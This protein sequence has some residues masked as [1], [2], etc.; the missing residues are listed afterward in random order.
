[1]LTGVGVL[2]AFGVLA[3]SYAYVGLV[4][5]PGQMPGAVFAAW[6]H[7]W[8]WFP[9]LVLILLFVPM[10]FPTGRPL[11][12]RWNWL[13]W[14]AVAVLTLMTVASWTSPTLTDGSIDDPAYAVPNPIGLGP[15]GTRFE[16]SALAG[17]LF[18]AALFLALC[19]VLS[20]IIRFRRSRDVERQQMKLFLY[21][22][23]L[24]AALPITESL[25]L[26]RFLPDTN[27]FFGI[28]IALPPIAIGVAV[29]RY[30]LYEIDRLISR[31][32][33]YA[34]LTALLIAVYLGS[35]T[36]LTAVTAPVTGDSPAAVAVATLVAAALF[37]PARR[38][39]Q[40]AVDRRFNRARYDAALTLDAYRAA[41]RDELDLTAIAAG[42][43]AAAD[44]TVE[45]SR[46]LV[47]LRP[48]TP[49]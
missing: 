39:I 25:G 13:Y 38:R 24:L 11:T 19:S 22:V 21:A 12:P 49:R 16:D 30:R 41:L 6:F 8:Y 2:T 4:V 36:A 45:P 26:H 5:R 3:E 35:V 29:T 7:N 27:L 33:T 42:L 43:Q 32:L 17:V 31:T 47:W 40:A 23:V 15:A 46:S 37:G 18:G 44:L 1:V 20:L 14:S 28:A 34:L 48:E 9:L 10:L